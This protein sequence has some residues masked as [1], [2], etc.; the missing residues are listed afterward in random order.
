MIWDEH[1]TSQASQKRRNINDQNHHETAHPRPHGRPNLE[2]QHLWSSWP[3]LSHLAMPWLGV[4]PA[5]YGV[6]LLTYLPEFLVYQYIYIYQHLKLE[7]MLI[8]NV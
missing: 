2:T 7:H 6:Y 8:S 3:Y 5:G 1:G 4:P